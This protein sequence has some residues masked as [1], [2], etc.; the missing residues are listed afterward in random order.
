MYL[1][2]YVLLD[3]VN[4]RGKV[5]EVMI[6]TYVGQCYRLILLSNMLKQFQPLI[7]CSVKLLLRVNSATLGIANTRNIKGCHQRSM[8]TLLKPHLIR[9]YLL[10]MAVA[11]SSNDKVL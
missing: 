9:D 3:K 4:L 8:V 5:V 11:F 10:S 6:E 7:I 2:F 1:V